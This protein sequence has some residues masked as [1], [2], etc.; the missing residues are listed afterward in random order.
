[1]LLLS[2]ISGRISDRR[3]SPHQATLGIAIVCLGLF[4]MATITAST[5][6][7]LVMARLAVIGIGTAVF[8]SPNSSAIMGSVPKDRL[9]TAS[10][11]V[12]TSRNIG[13]ASGLAMASSILVGVASSSAGFTASRIAD[14][15]E[16]AILDGIRAAFVVAAV[17]SSFA[18]IASSF[19]G[20]PAEDSALT[21]IPA[22]VGQK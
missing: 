17:M 16:D 2:P 18:V 7:W 8:M 21:P 9:G 3:A 11:S 12:A 13:N 4:S 5:P 20:K 15:P 6:I 14:L 22:P 19:R 1:M 10:A